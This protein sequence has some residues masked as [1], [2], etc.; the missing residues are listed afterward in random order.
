MP[1]GPAELLAMEMEMGLQY[2]REGGECRTSCGG[3]VELKIR[4]W[5]GV[6]SFLE[7]FP[8]QGSLNIAVSLS[9]IDTGPHRNTFRKRP[10]IPNSSYVIPIS[11]SS[12][13]DGQCL[14]G[15]KTF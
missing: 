3:R 6:A 14:M 15:V 5:V 7:T 2:W 11:T 9:N 13:D 12:T 1:R 10:N 8:P 4:V